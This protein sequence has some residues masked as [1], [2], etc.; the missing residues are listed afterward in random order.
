MTRFQSMEPRAV[1]NDPGKLRYAWTLM[2]GPWARHRIEVE[3]KH[4]RSKAVTITVDGEVLVEANAEDIECDE[5]NFDC[6]FTFRGTRRIDWEV[7]ESNTD[8]AVLDSKATV[9]QKMPYSV[10][11]L[12]T[13]PV[14]GALA[15]AELFII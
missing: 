12:V 15:N 7:Y 3:K 6:R 4:K 13:L 2:I 10:E 9:N 8:G 1:E 14:E 5:D 11:A